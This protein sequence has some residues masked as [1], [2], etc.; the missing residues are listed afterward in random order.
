MSIY[1]APY[2]ERR[3]PTA[4]IGRRVVAYIIDLVVPT[5]LFFI[6]FAATATSVDKQNTIFEGRNICDLLRNSSNASVCFEGN[7]TAFTLKGGEAALVILVPLLVGLANWVFVQSATGASVGKMITGL[8]VVDANGEPAGIGRNLLR[9]VFLL[10]DGICGVLGLVVAAVTTPHRRVG[11]FVAG[12]YVVQRDSTGSPV[13]AT[14]AAPPPPSQYTPFSTTGPGGAP[15]W[16]P[17]PA[18]PASTSPYA[19]PPAASYPPPPSNYG[20]PT[21]PPPPQATTPA[22]GSPGFDPAPP[23]APAPAPTPTPE[24]QPQPAPEPLPAPPLTNAQPAATT[25]SGP[26]APVWDATRNAWVSF[27]PAR[28]AWL[29]YD[30]AAKEWRPLD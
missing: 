22:F 8:R 15:T 30:D 10:I 2:A 28:N 20:V 23:P 7:N 27:D 29:R 9:W 21:S 19:P 25:R 26:T 13:G 18:P 24:P 12:T 3:D 4:V 16:P 17:T 1:N 6:L 5:A 14:G 11:D